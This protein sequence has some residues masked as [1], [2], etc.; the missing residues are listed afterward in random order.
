MAPWL[1][2]HRVI[3]VQGRADGQAFITCCRLDISSPKGSAIE[4]LAVRDA[5]ES[6]SARHR[7]IV[8]RNRLV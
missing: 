5:V 1:L 3:R 4:Q 2:E 7:Q 8:T 6:A